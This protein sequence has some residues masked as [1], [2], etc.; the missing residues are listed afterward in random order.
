MLLRTEKIIL[1]QVPHKSLK[2]CAW[3]LN[4]NDLNSSQYFS[5]GHEQT[6]EQTKMFRN[7]QKLRARNIGHNS[8][9]FVE[10]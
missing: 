7:E 6:I 4:Q 8:V 10:S 5:F 1:L 2:S 9:D 3:F